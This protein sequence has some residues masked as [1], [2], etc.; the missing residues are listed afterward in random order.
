MLSASVKFQSYKSPLWTTPYEVVNDLSLHQ[1][2][3]EY[4]N[5]NGNKL[6]NFRVYWILLLI[7]LFFYS[8]NKG[9]SINYV[10][11]KGRGGQ[12]FVM[13][14]FKSTEICTVLRYEWGGSE[15]LKNRVT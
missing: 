11:L 14:L 9:K 15:K 4:G 8:F 10:T 13:N 1:L 12:P 7:E 6:V 2:R 5:Y 3:K